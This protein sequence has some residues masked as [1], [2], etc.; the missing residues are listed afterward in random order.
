MIIDYKELWCSNCA[1]WVTYPN[2]YFKKGDN[3]PQ[4]ADGELLVK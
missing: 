1:F 3:C 4:C 2:E